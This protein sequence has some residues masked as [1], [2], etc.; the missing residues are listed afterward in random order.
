MKELRPTDAGLYFTK[1]DPDDQRLGETSRAGDSASKA[2]FHLVGWADDDGIRLNGG[3]P[4]AAEAPAR[5]RKYLY[6]MTPPLKVASPL[7][8]DWGDLAPATKGDLID[9]ASELAKRH[10]TARAVSRELL[11]KGTLFTLGGGHDYGF[12]DA[13]AFCAHTIA[14]GSRPVVLNFDAH[15][16]VRPAANGFHSGTPFRRLLEEFGSKV[17]FVEVGLQRQCNSPVHAEWAR[18]QGATLLWADALREQGGCTPAVSRALAAFRG[19]PLWVSLDI[20]A[21][22]SS[23]APGCSQSWETGLPAADVLQTLRF[24]RASMVFAGMGIYEVSPPL[25]HDDR[26]SKLA[27]LC[28]YEM[29]FAQDVFAGARA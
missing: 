14:Q 24:L 12:P 1:N 23:A 22:T 3:R 2:R 5:I 27:A 15:L 25:D 21:V 8:A 28:V 9:G 11:G 17:D 19:R 26:T 16:D 13:A 18:S 4:G 7:I 10:E 29:I 20:D 6:K